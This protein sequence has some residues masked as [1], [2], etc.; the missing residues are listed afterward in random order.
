M[1]NLPVVVLVVPLLIC[2]IVSDKMYL[3]LKIIL[4]LLS[5][6]GFIFYLSHLYNCF[7]YS[8]S[9]IKLPREDFLV[10]PLI[11]HQDVH[12]YR[13]HE[14]VESM[15]ARSGSFRD[16]RSCSGMFNVVN[17]PNSAYHVYSQLPMQAFPFSICKLTDAKNPFPDFAKGSI[18]QH[19]HCP[20]GEDFARSTNS[21]LS[22][23]CHTDAYSSRVLGRN[24]EMKRDS[25][26]QSVGTSSRKHGLASLSQEHQRDLSK[27][28]TPLA[29]DELSQ[30]PYSVGM[31]SSGRKTQIGSPQSP[32]K[33]DCQPNSPTESSSSKNA[34]L[35]HTSQPLTPQGTQDPKARNWKKYKFIVLNQSTKEEE[36][37]AHEPEMRSPQR[38]AFHPSSE[39]EHPDM[40]SASTKITG[41]GDDFTVPQAS[42][43]NN[44]INR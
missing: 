31:A 25:V 9:S 12:G 27:E 11:L 4:N 38:L 1:C 18:L 17:P 35:S 3:I 8:D 23:S 28:Q 34:A 19:K 21:S 36:S 20:P 16:G 6:V 22:S 44:I 26:A 15:A 10:S 39:S 30:R 24:D 32:L 43:L 41:H 14:V 37:G 2:S 29:E 13:P 7:L 5:T 40:Q 33:S 42:R